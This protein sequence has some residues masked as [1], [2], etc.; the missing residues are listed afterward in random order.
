MKKEMKIYYTEFL[1]DYI[2][3]IIVDIETKA[4]DEEEVIDALKELS[5]IAVEEL[6]TRFDTD[7]DDIDLRA[8]EIKL[9]KKSLIFDNDLTTSDG[10]IIALGKFT[11]NQTLLFLLAV[12]NEM[13]ELVRY[14]RND[15]TLVKP[16][17]SLPISE[18]KYSSKLN[19][20]KSK[21]F[22][23]RYQ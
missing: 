17:W 7:I 14:I 19:L 10:D 8:I 18:F 23:R 21:L 16:H 6:K 13:I 22:F 11:T 1:N 12:K 5:Q 9:N 20:E 2:G 15:S 3:K 4:V